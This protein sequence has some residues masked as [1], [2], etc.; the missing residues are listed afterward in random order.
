MENFF[1]WFQG[2]SLT[3]SNMKLEDDIP[4]VY[5]LLSRFEGKHFDF[6]FTF[7]PELTV[8]DS[9]GFS[10]EEIKYWIDYTETNKKDIWNNAV[11]ILHKELYWR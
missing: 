11:K 3:H 2:V 6:I 7:L 4:V 1:S 8:I 5:V 10:D 9:K